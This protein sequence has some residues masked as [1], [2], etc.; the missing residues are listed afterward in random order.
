M[1]NLFGYLKNLLYFCIAIKNNN[2]MNINDLQKGDWV[3]L[4][5]RHMSDYQEVFDA[6]TRDE[7]FYSVH[8]PRQIT[9]IQRSDRKSVV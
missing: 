3:I 6:E 1:T 4:S 5:T 7:L 2:I 8:V 9:N